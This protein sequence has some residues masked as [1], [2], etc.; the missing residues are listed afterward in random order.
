MR[1]REDI[2]EPAGGSGYVSPQGS[3]DV[4]LRAGVHSGGGRVTITYTVNATTS[5]TKSGT[6]ATETLIGTSGVATTP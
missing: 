3:T 5:C 4:Q 2:R 1:Q 6:S